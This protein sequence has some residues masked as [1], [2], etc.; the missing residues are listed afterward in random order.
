MAPLVQEELVALQSL[1]L[2]RPTARVWLSSREGR[3]Q[4][5][6]LRAAFIISIDHTKDDVLVDIRD[7]VAWC[8]WCG[9]RTASFC[10]HCDF[11]S[12]ERWGAI[13]TLCDAAER[14]CRTCADLVSLHG[15]RR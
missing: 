3:K 12:F 11:M 1:A 8:S 2:S 13:C 14:R 10:D 5:P 6:A 15:L 7:L 4:C 9:L